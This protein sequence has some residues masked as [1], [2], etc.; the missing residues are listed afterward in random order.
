MYLEN[1]ILKYEKHQTFKE[2]E[3]QRH[4][5]KFPKKQTQTIEKDAHLL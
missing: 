5:T 2:R 3:M 4:Q 1:C